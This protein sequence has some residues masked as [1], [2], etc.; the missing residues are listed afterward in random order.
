MTSGPIEAT[1]RARTHV[2]NLAHALKT[3][4]SVLVNEARGVDGPLARHVVEQAGLMREHVRH[5]LDRARIAAQRRVIGVVTEVAPVV[6]RLAR[7]G[8]TELAQACFD[9]LPARARLDLMGWEEPND[10]F[11]H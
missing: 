1:E 4:L 10:I 11:H 6:E 8:R 9:F 2:G 5:H 3:P 7:E